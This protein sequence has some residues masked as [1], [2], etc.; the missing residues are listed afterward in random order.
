M[1]TNAT[2]IDEDEIDLKEVFRTIFRYKYM[3]IAFV[4]LFGAG[5]SFF[6]YFKPNV[7]K[8]TS[9]IEIGFNPSANRGM[10]G[11]DMMSMAMDG[12]AMT[13]D[14]EIAKI[15]S[16]TLAERIAQKIDF[17]HKYYTERRFKEL[18]LYVNSPFKVAMNKGYGISFDL[19]PIDNKLYR[20]VVKDA[21][22]E[23]KTV[24]S[25][26]KVLPYDKEVVT[27]HFH[28][29]VTRTKAFD[30]TQYRFV[31]IDPAKVGTMIRES[32]SVSQPGKTAMILEIS[33]EDNV[34]LRAQ[35]TANAL[36]EAYIQQ[37]IEYKTQEA[38]LKLKFI[39]EQLNR[40]NEN[41]KAS[42]VKLEEFK[43]SANTVNLSAK[44][45]S[46]LSNMSQSELKLQEISIHEGLLKILYD[47]VK[48]GKNLESLSGS[49]FGEEGA[50]L[51]SLIMELQK[52]I[53]QK[54]ALRES[55][56]ELYP[57]VRA[58]TKTIS[59]QKKVIIATIENLN[60]SIQ[61]RKALLEKSIAEQQELLNT[62]PADERMYGQ[63]ERKFVVNEK[64]YSYL[65]EQRSATAI[66]KAAT[67]SKNHIIDT[68]LVP[69]KPIKPKRK[70]IVL[71]GL[72]LGLIVGIAL[73]FL[74]AFLDDR[75]KS[76]E[77]ITHATDVPLLGVIPHIK[78]DANK[79]K[80]FEAPKSSVAEAFRNLRTNLQFMQHEGHSHVIALT[81]TVG[82]EGK[83]TACVNLGAIMSMAEK[84]TIILNLDM[85]KPT[86]HEK[87]E[88]RN[89]VGMST[90]LTGATPLE[91]VIQPT[92]Y[93][94]LDL[95]TSGPVPPNPSELIQKEIL[96]QT[97]EALRKMYDV[98]ILDTP[99]VGLVADAR[100][101]MHYADTS[102]YLLRAEYSKRD[103]IKSINR[104][105]GEEI[106]SFG[107]LFNDVTQANGSYG[108][109][110]GYGYG[111]YDDD[112]K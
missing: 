74:R 105:S 87:F 51:S 54:R 67:V 10:M 9:T 112:K 24:W 80:V 97:I 41:L 23:N 89:K 76:E 50:G 13:P 77:D 44:A 47:Q 72:I 65:L 48:S 46:I 104:L 101:L 14:T 19:Y 16:R 22:D 62:L 35:Q 61:E 79:L 83:T 92:K 27:E 55:Y 68:A 88:V 71:V 33:Y 85:R 20:L 43:R 60:K 94:N 11:M 49:G 52:A 30:N 102:I 70:L 12:G 73:A 103:Y 4:I 59:Q 42:A 84:R 1:N 96:K 25:Y 81:S 6:A 98:I 63:L 17:A 36:A 82:A 90:L 28:L 56:T 58:L 64:I 66:I 91:K 75:I 15:K 31:V 3:I 8:A 5:S 93:A 37:N 78:E 110:Y 21:E 107:I 34:A 106:G 39:D 7:Y 69:E 26:D 32:V 57:E 109:G 45:E 18:E 111:Y 53:I 40:I 38:S 29:N 99:P 95:I 100:T 108:Y 86:L 2:Q